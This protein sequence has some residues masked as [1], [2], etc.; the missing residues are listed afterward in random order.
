MFP[1]CGKTALLKE[2]VQTRRAT[3]RY[4]IKIECGRSSVRV[5][6]KLAI[7]QEENEK[8]RY[9]DEKVRGEAVR[10]WAGTVWSAD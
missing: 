1:I 3:G 9:C 7:W 4:Y 8:G 10:K 2:W 6:N 5:K